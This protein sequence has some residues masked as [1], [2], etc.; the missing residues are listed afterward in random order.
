MKTVIYICP[1]CPSFLYRRTP[2]TLPSETL[3]HAHVIRDLKGAHGI[4]ANYCLGT[5][6]ALKGVKLSL[7]YTRPM[8][9][10]KKKKK[11]KKKR[12]RCAQGEIKASRVQVQYEEKG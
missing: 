5:R 1:A 12:Q 3:C 7:G 11:R 6:L 4:D 10:S 2:D 8:E 9:R